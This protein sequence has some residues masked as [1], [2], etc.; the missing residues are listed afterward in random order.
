MPKW[1][2][3]LCIKRQAVDLTREPLDRRRARRRPGQGATDAPKADLGVEVVPAQQNGKL[4]QIACQRVALDRS[5]SHF[6]DPATLYGMTL[7]ND[8]VTILCEE[9]L[10][11]SI[12]FIV[13]L[14]GLEMAIFGYFPGLTE[15]A[16]IESTAM[17]FVLSAAILCILSFIA[18]LG[19]E[20]RRMER[21]SAQFS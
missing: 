12:A 2:R 19:H 17:L 13:M 15:P 4:A 1:Q 7:H 14:I 18:G 20:L 6:R 11:G 9:G 16:S 5:R 21:S 10:V 3:F 8:Y